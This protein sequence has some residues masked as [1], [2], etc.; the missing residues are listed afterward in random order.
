[1]TRFAKAVAVVLLAL[2]VAGCAGARFER[3]VPAAVPAP[4]ETLEGFAHKEAWFGLVF[5]GERVG[6]THYKVEKLAPGLYEIY[7][8]GYFHI[9]FMGTDQKF[10]VKSWD[11]V[12]SRLELVSSKSEEKIGK[13]LRKVT[14]TYEDGVLHIEIAVSGATSKLSLPVKGPLYPAVAL[15]FYPAFHGL[16][17]GEEYIYLV[18]D[19]EGTRIASAKQSVG[20]LMK[21]PDLFTGE[22]YKISSEMAG[23]KTT[24]YVN[25]EG[26]T[27]LERTLGGALIRYPE[28]EKVAKSYLAAAA[29]NKRDLIL[30]IS[31]VEVDKNI[32]CPR[33]ITRLSLMVSGLKDKIDPISD[34]R[35]SATFAGDGTKFSVDI[36]RE[37]DLSREIT[38][39]ERIIYTLSTP[40]VESDHPDI[41]AKAEEISR[42]AKSESDTVETLVKWVDQNVKNTYEDS[43]TA[44]G[45][46]QDLKGECQAHTLLYT[47]LARAR[48]LPTRVISGLIYLEGKGFVY[49]AWAE[50]YAD[51][52]WRTVDPTFGQVNADATHIKLTQGADFFE[53]HAI[54]E[55]IGKIK[56]KVFSFEPVCQEKKGGPES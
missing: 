55:L 13:K 42:D 8:E 37:S 26:L 7:S 34:G 25:P 20:Y 35:Q 4:V 52:R 23:V 50:S 18:F 51:G 24:S 21:N 6:F 9:R 27:L 31:K 15:E 14:G 41:A 16:I 2:F 53:A 22:G 54:T 46:L 12:T 3:V 5:S 10:S 19:A 33:E 49:H 17:E 38:K 40:S 11:R 48:K 1:M 29:L 44:L 32:P 56:V 43:F 36:F 47:A 30:D 28:S 39:K 45:V